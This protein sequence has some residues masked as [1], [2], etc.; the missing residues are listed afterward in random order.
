VDQNGHPRPLLPRTFNSFSQMAGENAESRIYLGIHWQ[1]D[2][3]EGIRSGD[4][5]GDY[6]FTHALKP[7]QGGPP[8]ALPSM[9]PEAQIALAVQLEDV[10]AHGGLQ[11]NGT[12]LTG[13]S[14]ALNSSGVTPATA[15][16]GA[17]GNTAADHA[18][19][20]VPTGVGSP[21]ATASVSKSPSQTLVAQSAETTTQN[22]NS[23]RI[24][25]H[26]QIPLQQ[27]NHFG[28]AMDWDFGMGQGLDVFTQPS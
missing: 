22:Q 12:G 15:A 4:G 23:E 28:D 3:V 7:L 11:G 20:A 1:F 13:A 2:A 16:L 10:A 6:V 24:D 18:G 8:Q 5:I 26:F 19:A 17:A 9:D 27:V 25:K 14:F 21:G